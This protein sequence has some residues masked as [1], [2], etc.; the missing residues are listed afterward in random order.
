MRLAAFCSVALFTTVPGAAQGPRFDVASVKFFTQNIPQPYTVT[1][2]PGTSGPIRFR[3]PRIALINLLGR[4]FDVSTDQITGP[5][6]IRDVA[7]NTY[8][9]VATMPPDTTKEQFRQMLQN[10]LAERFHMVFH[11]E[12]RNFPGYALVVDKGGPKFRE[13]DS[14][15]PANAP[16]DTRL[17]AMMGSGTDD[18][19]TFLPAREL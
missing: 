15:V 14:T 3:A 5:S 6:W 7:A 12:T 8:T 1:G 9:V 11:R 19:P 10:L 17:I 2:G 18:F 16:P 4:A 13:V